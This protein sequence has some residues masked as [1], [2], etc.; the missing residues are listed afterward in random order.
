[1]KHKSSL[2]LVDD[3]HVLYRSGT[4]RRLHTPTKHP[5]NPVIAGQD[6]PWEVAVAWNS[7]HRDPVTGRY[8]LWYQ[9]YTG[10]SRND[11]TSCPVCYAESSDGINWE[12]PEL[13]LFPFKGNTKNNIVL[14]GNGGHSHRYCASVI[15]DPLDQDASR[16]YKMAYTDFPATRSA[17]GSVEGWPGV[18]VAFSSD[19]IHWTKHSEHP[20]LR[21]SYGGHGPVPD[22]G[23]REFSWWDKP[24]AMSDALDSI[25]DPIRECFVLY[26]KMWYDGP[27][28]DMYWKHG[29]G[30]TESQ[31]FVHWSKPELIL[32]PDEFDPAYVEF[33]HTPVF[34]YSGCYFALPQILNRAERGGIM[35]VELAISRDGIHWQRPFRSPF[36]L[37]KSSVP[38]AFDS[39]SIFT[40]STPII[41][42]DEIRFYYGAYSEG[43]TSGDDDY[44]VS[45]I[46]LATLPRDRFAG[47]LPMESIAQITFKPIEITPGSGIA[48]NADASNGAMWLEILD[49]DA[50]RVPGFRREEAV[51][52]TGDNLRHEPRWQSK[53][54]ADLP[55]GTYHLR[56]HLDN[57][58]VFAISL[59]SI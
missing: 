12:K 52:I 1:M 32:T 55:A 2:L 31:D 53:T 26:G 20:L 45:G 49:A 25:Y 30:R 33:H 19:G 38:D 34:Y 10:L 7:L 21:G 4:T 16:R 8:Q 24:L 42:D 46:G 9:S 59:K 28:G 36:F 35:D 22:S 39:G 37:A 51:P 58:E 18:A 50:Y 11:P 44:Q 47:L 57:A 56:L 6:K 29:L 43:A 17:P 14:I 23:T 5:T 3:E 15:V 41:L 13:D 27:D 40:N 54:L 48:I